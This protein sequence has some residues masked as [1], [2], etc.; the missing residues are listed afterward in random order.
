MAVEQNRE[1]QRQLYG[2]PLGDLAGRIPAVSRRQVDWILVGGS[3]LVLLGGVVLLAVALM[4][5]SS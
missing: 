5:G 2:E 3:A 1:V 4:G